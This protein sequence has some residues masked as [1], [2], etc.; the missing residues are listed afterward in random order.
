MTDEHSRP[1]VADLQGGR[2]HAFYHG[3]GKPLSA[4]QGWLAT[5]VVGQTVIARSP[6]IAFGW[7][8][9]CMSFSTK[10]KVGEGSRARVCGLKNGRPS[11]L[12]YRC[13]GAEPEVECEVAMTCRNVSPCTISRATVLQPLIARLAIKPRAT[14]AGY[15]T[16]LA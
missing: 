11:P 6:I 4:P 7:A 3:R 10:G 9:C 12:M 16:G 13:I 5:R 2:H 8:S 15:L 1:T 14:S